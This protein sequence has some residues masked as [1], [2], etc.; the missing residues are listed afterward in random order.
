MIKARYEFVLK[1]KDWTLEDWKKVI[2]TDETSVCLGV[3]RGKVR[4]WRTPAE[5]YDPTV[6]RR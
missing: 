1:Y 3:Q 2:W 6:I 4:V 5:I